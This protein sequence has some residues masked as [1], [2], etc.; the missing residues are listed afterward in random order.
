MVAISDVVIVQPG[1]NEWLSET[2]LLLQ[3]TLQGLMGYAEVVIAEKEIVSHL[4]SLKR[5]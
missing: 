3:L 4:Q 1:H 2:N 5:A